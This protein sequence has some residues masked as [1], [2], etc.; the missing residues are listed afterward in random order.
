[1]SSEDEEAPRVVVLLGNESQHRNTLA[2]LIE[3]GINIVGVVIAEN[4]TIGLPLKYIIKS[5]SRR[6]WV[7]TISQVLARILYKARN[8][9][10]DK[11]LKTKIF[12]D[13]RNKKIISEIVAP[14]VVDKNYSLQRNFILNLKPEILIVHTGSWIGK[15][16]RELNSVK[17]VIG[18]HPGITPI[19]RGSHSPF[20]A[21]Y[22][23]DYENIGW[24]CFLVDKGVDTGPVLEQGYIVPSEEETYM[25]LSWR[26]MKEIA[27]SQV[28]A[29]K[30]YSSSGII[31]SIPHKLIPDNSEYFLPTL[32]EQIHFWFKQKKVK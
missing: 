20:W 22:N 1:M 27:L 15:D 5:A 18:G 23:R 28:K 6:G 8:R 10:R 13:A 12:D 24:T 16:I 11:K 3:N 17:Y 30:T 19:Y 29:I 7:K 26:G 14:I 31:S 4:K 25:S 21:I 2:T 9:T 32:S